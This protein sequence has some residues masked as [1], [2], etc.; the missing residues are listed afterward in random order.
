M[1]KKY[2]LHKDFARY[3]SPK[4]S[5]SPR[6]GRILNRLI[7]IDRFL[8]CRNPQAGLYR[9][10]HY[11]T[12]ADGY[13]LPCIVIGPTNLTKPAP[14]V[15]YYHGGAYVL[16][17]MTLH[18]KMCER[19]A[20]EANCVVVLVDYRLALQ[21]Q[22]PTSFNDSYAALE[23]TIANAKLLGIDTQRV[24]VMGDS[25]GGGMAASVAQKAFDNNIALRSQVLIYPT[26]DSECKT[27]SATEFTDTPLFNAISNRGMWEQYL[28]NYLSNPPEYAAAGLR[29][30][31]A[32][33]P[34]AYINTAEFDPLRD[35]GIAYAHA[36]EAAGVSTI[37]DQTRAT[38]HG[39][40]VVAKNSETIRAIAAR[41]DFLKKSFI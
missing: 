32:G 34:P 23:W 13:A 16:S 17:H 7:S 41:V 22:F 4:S 37:L 28:G 30:N 8:R 27:Y 2:A 9:T 35:E 39:F 11:A 29:K 25:A 6:L 36:L 15:V 18:V 31:L 19:Y 14:M 1:N 3:P 38:M 12:M 20:L 24:V 5:F 40:D 10:T 26:V 21:H 33:L